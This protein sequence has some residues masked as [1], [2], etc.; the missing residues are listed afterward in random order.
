MQICFSGV[1]TASGVVSHSLHD[2]SVSLSSSL[3]AS[4]I[5]SLLVGIGHSDLVAPMST[6]VEL[7][8]GLDTAT[9][10]EN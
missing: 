9:A 2:L 7:S 3:C 4:Q 5:R 8:V 10:K 6:K 1:L